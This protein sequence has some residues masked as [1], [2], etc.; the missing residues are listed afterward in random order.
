MKEINEKNLEKA[1]GG[2]EF[3]KGGFMSAGG[4]FTSPYKP[5][6]PNG[7][8]GE[9]S[10]KPGAALKSCENCQY[11]VTV[12]GKSFCSRFKYDVASRTYVLI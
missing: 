12:A 6:E 7:S 5:T 1:V 8:C 4:E 3:S 9:F 11:M 2:M 10:S